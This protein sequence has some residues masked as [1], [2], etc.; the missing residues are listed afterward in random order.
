MK[1]LLIGIA[2][3]VGL[4]SAAHAD[5]VNFDEFPSPPVTCCYFNTGVHGP[6]TYPHVTV[7]SPG[8]GAVMN[9]LG[10]AN[11]QTSGFNLYGTLTGSMD[12]TFTLG[13]S[14]LSFDLINGTFS[15]SDFNV[16]LSGANGGTQTFTLNPWQSAGS[17]AHLSF[18]GPG[19]TG[20]HID[21]NGDFAIDTIKFD[22]GSVPEPASWALMLGGFGLVGGA[23][24]SGRKASASFA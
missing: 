3:G 14:N 21:G 12:L 13:V 18:A 1:A 9:G 6:L 5:T 19:I 10:W 8:G 24:R 7:S 23:L 16:T 11:E 20:A 15:V 2:A 4:A 17:V 22:T